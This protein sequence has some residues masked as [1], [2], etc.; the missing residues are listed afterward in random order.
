M[1]IRVVCLLLCAAAL[2]AADLTGKWSG[3][4]DTKDP[5]GS[6]RPGSAYLEL[7]QSGETV[8]GTAGPDIDRQTPIDKGKVTGKKLTFEVTSGHDGVMKFELTVGEE[9]IEGDVRQEIG[10]KPS[11]RT[12]WL[13]VARVK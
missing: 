7:K 6:T 1:R 10:G 8:S 9:R 13:S 2:V 3:S 12:A 4:F 5:D 11:G